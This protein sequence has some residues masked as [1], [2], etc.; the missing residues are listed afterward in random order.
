[1]NQNPT[2]G[3][4]ETPTCNGKDITKDNKRI[5]EGDVEV[6]LPSAVGVPSEGKH[7]NG[8]ECPRGESEE[9]SD[10]GIEPEGLCDTREILTE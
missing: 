9:Q 6:P 5:A 8:S 10:R 2:S 1:M 3:V 7:K 4:W